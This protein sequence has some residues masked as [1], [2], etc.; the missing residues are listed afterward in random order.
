[1]TCDPPVDSELPCRPNR[2]SGRDRMFH[3]K[4]HDDPR[5]A[6]TASGARE[7]PGTRVYDQALAD[8]QAATEKAPSEKIKRLARVP[9]PGPKNR[10]SPAFAHSSPWHRATPRVGVVPTLVISLPTRG[11]TSSDREQIS[12]GRTC[13]RFLCVNRKG[14]NCQ[15]HA[16]YGPSKAVI[17]VDEIKIFRF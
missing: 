16:R 10:R 2:A 13:Y 14:W 12:N 9:L 1:M 8:I 6:E 4:R 15:G 3:V 7:G 11:G 17:N 5:L